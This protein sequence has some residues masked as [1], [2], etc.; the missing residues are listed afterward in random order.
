MGAIRPSSLSLSRTTTAASPA[1]TRISTPRWTRPTGPESS[2]ISPT[3]RAVSSRSQT[4]SSRHSRRQP[5]SQASP[6]SPSSALMWPPTPRVTCPRSRGSLPARSRRMARTRSPLLTTRWG[7]TCCHAGWLSTSARGRNS[8]LC[9][10]SWRSSAT[11]PR[12][13]PFQAPSGRA[14]PRGTTSTS[15]RPAARATTGT[16]TPEGGIGEG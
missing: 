2:L 1:S 10:T 12:R 7:I 3:A 11:P 6:G 13:R 14:R 16:R 5:V 15:S 4:T 9:P 8:P